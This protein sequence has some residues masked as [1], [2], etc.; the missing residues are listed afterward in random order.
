MAWT[1]DDVEALSTS[2]RAGAD[3]AYATGLILCG[4]TLPDGQTFEDLVR[5]TFCLQQAGGVWRVT[6]QHISKPFEIRG[7]A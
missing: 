4:G 3:V 2:N 1:R 6:H 7:R 5:A